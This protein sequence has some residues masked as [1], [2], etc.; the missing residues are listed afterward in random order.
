M[1]A[2]L[3]S[4]LIREEAG[5]KLGALQGDFII[6]AKGYHSKETGL[7]NRINNTHKSVLSIVWPKVDL[8]IKRDGK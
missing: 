5:L 6:E 2:S 4:G 1:R 3:R 8:Q 7:N